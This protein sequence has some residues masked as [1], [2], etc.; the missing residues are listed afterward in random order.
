MFCFESN[1]SKI[2]SAIVRNGSPEAADGIVPKDIDPLKMAFL[3]K[4]Y[5]TVVGFDVREA[6]VVRGRPRGP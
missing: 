3:L 1:T 6:I 2:Y 5:N 4:N